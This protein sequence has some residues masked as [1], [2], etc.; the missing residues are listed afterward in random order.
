[1]SDHVAELGAGEDELLGFLSD[2]VASDVA[3]LREAHHEVN[4]V[5]ESDLVRSGG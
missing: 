2:K 5:V 1:M 4:V 3:C